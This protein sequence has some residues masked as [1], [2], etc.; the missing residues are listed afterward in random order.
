VEGTDVNSPPS[1]SPAISNEKTASN[2]D[3]DNK[4]KLVAEV[5]AAAAAAAVMAAMKNTS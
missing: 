5:A 4:M 3:Q 2:I 1:A